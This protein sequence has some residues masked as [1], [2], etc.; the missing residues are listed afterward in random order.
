MTVSTIRPSFTRERA[1]AKE[2]AAEDAWMSRR[3][4]SVN[5]AP[6]SEGERRLR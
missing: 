3:Y 6:I 1:A 5:D 2:Q 4:A